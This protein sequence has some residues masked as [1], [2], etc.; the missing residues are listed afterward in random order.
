MI[1][2]RNRVTTADDYRAAVRRG[3]RT[4]A[5]L[6]TVHIRKTEHPDARFGFIVAKTVGNAAHR[7]LVR[8]RLKSIAH[9]RLSTVPA[10]T[11]IV[12]R[13]LPGSAQAP[14]V[15]LNAQI[16]HALSKGLTRA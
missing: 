9:D 11:D 12:I 10:G 8:R 13:A 5:P 14:W 15:S 2:R 3:V 16:T 4:S 7:N 6:A 1:A